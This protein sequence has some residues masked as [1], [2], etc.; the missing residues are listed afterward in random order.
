MTP[1]S[2]QPAAPKLTLVLAIVAITLTLVPAGGARLT[3]R[4]ARRCVEG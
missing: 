1:R 3:Q 4:Y 2:Y